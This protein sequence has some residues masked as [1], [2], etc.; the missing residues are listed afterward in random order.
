MVFFTMYLSFRI[1]LFWVY[2]CEFSGVYLLYLFVANRGLTTLHLSTKMTPRFSWF[3]IECVEY[4]PVSW[5]VAKKNP[6]YIRIIVSHFEGSCF[7]TNLRHGMSKDVLK[8]CVSVVPLPETSVRTTLFGPLCYL[9]IFQFGI[10][11]HGFLFF[12]HFLGS[13]GSQPKPSFA[14]DC[15]LGWVGGWIQYKK[16]TKTTNN[17]PGT[18][19]FGWN[20][21]F[22]GIFWLQ[23]DTVIW[24]GWARSGR[25]TAPTGAWMLEN[26]GLCN[27]VHP[28]FLGGE[29][30]PVILLMAEIRLTSWGEGSFLSH[31][32][33]KVL[34]IQGGAGFQ[35]STVWIYE[36]RTDIPLRV[37]PMVF[38]WCSTSGVLGIQR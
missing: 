22:S 16:H 26:L 2:P 10:Y 36:S 20:P 30:Y 17:P 25:P 8:G 13:L 23:L 28:F 32:F 29:K 35:P 1:W 31:F 33:K 7:W 21:D 4:Y 14:Q 37:I 34:Y 24:G 6:C 18:Q 38:S 15:I 3:W 12:Y 19:P 5:A 9:L 11:P 27:C